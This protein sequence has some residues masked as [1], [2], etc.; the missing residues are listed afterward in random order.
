MPSIFIE[1][2]GRVTPQNPEFFRM[3]PERQAEEVDGIIKAAKGAGMITPPVDKSA[4]LNAL[5]PNS[6][7]AAVNAAA[8]ENRK[9]LVSSAGNVVSGIAHTVMH[10]VDTLEGMGTIG[11]GILQKV[12]AIDGK[13]AVPAADAVGKALVDRY[14]SWEN[15]KKTVHEDPVGFMMDASAALGLGGAAVAKAPGAL[16]AAG[17]IAKTAGSTFDPLSVAGRVA[18]PIVKTAGNT[19]A[20]IAGVTTGAGSEAL[21]VAA[22][23]GA[24][25]GDAAQAFR[26]GMSGDNMA[27]VVNEAKGAV[28]QL[29]QERGAQYTQA[30]EK[31]NKQ[32]SALGIEN[33]VLDFNK[34]D[35]AVNKVSDVKNFKGQDLSPSTAAI[36]DEMTKAIEDWKA[37]PA[38]QFH[39]VEGMDALKQKLGDMMDGAQPGTPARKVAGEIYNGVRQTIIDQAPEYAKIMKGYEQASDIIREIEST[40]SLKPKANIDTSLRKLQSVLR[41]N[42]STNYGRRAELVDFLKRAGAPNLIEKLAGQTL[43]AVAPRGLAR[44]LAGGEGLGAAALALHNPAAAA[45][46][47]GIGAGAAVSSSPRIIG[48][49]AYGLG[50]S[51]RIPARVLGQGAYQLNHFAQ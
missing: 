3:P 5:G 35:A 39:T 44:L 17:E 38:T 25:G 36:R 42:V 10:P 12:G 7:E 8:A 19:A 14:G 31:L 27:S 20:Q 16:G 21:K 41:D 50:A 1:G 22:R 28:S 34:V 46:A 45:T 24:E 11:K 37:L 4:A 48:S 26:E 40:L 51:T 9:N 23:A 29:R 2:V 18:A 47:L 49:A 6:D 32:D 13:D 43:S 33:Q 30:M 15:I